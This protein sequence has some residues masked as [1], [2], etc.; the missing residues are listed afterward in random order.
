MLYLAVSQDAVSAALIRE[1]GKQHLPI[2]FVSKTM[3]EVE[4]RYL[5]L[6]K[7]ALALVCAARKLRHYFQAHTVRVLTENPL[8]AILQKTDRFGRLVK[9]AIE[10]SEHDI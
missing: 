1:Q 7:L 8:R 9:W 3:S 10:L 5:P 6:E 4:T 2:Y